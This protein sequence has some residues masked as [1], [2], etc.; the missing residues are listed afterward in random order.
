MSLKPTL[1]KSNID[2]FIYFPFFFLFFFLEGGLAEKAGLQYTNHGFSKLA[3]SLI[4]KIQVV[5]Q[6]CRADH[7]TPLGQFCP[8][9]VF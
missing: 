1:L 7:H 9:G 5:T 2:L 4:L 6:H 3:K 8:T